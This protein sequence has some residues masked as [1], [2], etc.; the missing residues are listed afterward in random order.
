MKKPQ[1]VLYSQTVGT[2]VADQTRELLPNSSLS[3]ALLR[4]WMKP[5]VYGKQFPMSAKTLKPYFIWSAANRKTP[6]KTLQKQGLTSSFL[7]ALLSSR[8]M[9]SQD[10]VQ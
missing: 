8:T 4:S 1:A 5:L 2:A 7:L 6:P 9:Q 10:Q 3:N